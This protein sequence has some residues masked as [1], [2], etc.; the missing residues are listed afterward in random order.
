MT[1]ATECNGNSWHLDK[2]VPIALIAAILLQTGT[3][4]WWVAKQGAT[5]RQNSRD[6]TLMRQDLD[7]ERELTS[8]VVRIETLLQSMQMTLSE[9]R[10]DLRERSK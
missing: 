4:I 3:A 8:R 5:I 6:I 10:G 7:K 1:D 9:I 2:R